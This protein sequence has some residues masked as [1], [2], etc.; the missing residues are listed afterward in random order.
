MRPALILAVFLALP[1]HA[2][3]DTLYKCVDAH[4]KIEY[5]NQPCRVDSAPSKTFKVA[6]APD[7]RTLAREEDDRKRQLRRVND[8]LAS[9]ERMRENE[10]RQQA[11]YDAALYRRGEALRQREEQ[12]KEQKLAKSRAQ[13]ACTRRYSSAYCGR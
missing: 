8:D 13:S 2:S 6:A 9:R 10:A 1:F 4:G 12:I 7:D 5:A 11:S 3:A